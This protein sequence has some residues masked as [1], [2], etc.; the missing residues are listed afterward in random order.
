MTERIPKIF[1]FFWSALL[2]LILLPSTVMAADV[3]FVPSLRSKAEYNDNVSF[4]RINEKDDYLA[5]VSPDLSLLYRTEL[6]DVQSRVSADVLRYL[7]E[8]DLN[9]ENYQ[10]LFNGE[11][12]LMERWRASGSFAYI[13]DTTLESELEETG[14]V[15]VRE[16]R[17]RY[18]LGIGLSYQFS[19]L[20]DIAMNYTRRK[21]D[22]D[23]PANVD[24]DSDAIVFSYNQ[25]LTRKRDSFTIQ[26]YYTRT[27]SDVSEVDNHGLSLGWSHRF[28][29]TLSFEGL[30]GIR[31]TKI[32]FILAERQLTFDPIGN[33]IGLT[34]GKANATDR[35]WGA[36]GD[37]SLRKTG[38]I[39]SAVV[40]YR[41]D[42]GYSAIGEPIETDKIYCNANRLFTRRLGLKLTGSLY[43]TRSEGEFT[44]IDNRY[45][46]LIPS[47]NYKITE[48][49]SL[50]LAYSYSRSYD[51]TLESNREAERNRVWIAL[52][53][54]FPAKS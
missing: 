32:N 43:F 28:S 22:Y 27:D 44:D 10:G 20:S 31:Y 5:I 16:D 9:T 8:I 34:F 38:E 13:K 49:H 1:V 51:N 50:Q 33:S 19:E 47:L 39:F 24:Y 29:E 41:R 35:N 48:N 30:I 36:V 52:D 23:F 21:T 3:T 7:D 45:F 11:Y 4:T 12:R 14:L 18:N 37:I 15:N 42:L 53:L 54:R 40:G 26:S 17:E 6:I 2:F 46:D 25:Q